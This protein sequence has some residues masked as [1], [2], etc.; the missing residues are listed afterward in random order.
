MLAVVSSLCLT[1]L[2]CALLYQADSRRAAFAE[3]KQSRPIRFGLRFVAGLVFII[4]LLVMAPLQG[5]LRGVSIWLGLLS[6]VFVSGLF[7][8]AQRPS[9]H[10]PSAMI[11]GSAG[12]IALIGTV[13]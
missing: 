3:V 12:I 13:L 11:A 6:F 8:A 2:A 10:A 5:W 1:Y 7:I 9:W 4:S